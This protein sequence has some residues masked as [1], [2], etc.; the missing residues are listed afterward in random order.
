MIQGETKTE[1]QYRAIYLDSS[2]SLKDFSMDR[3]KYHKKY[4]LNQVVEDEESKA[5]TTGRLV[6]TLLMSLIY[7]MRS[8]TYLHVC[9]HQQL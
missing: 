7:L 8:S 6:E 9:L 4:I 1:A 5:A 3:K 2:S